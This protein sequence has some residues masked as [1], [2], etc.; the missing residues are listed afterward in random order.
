MSGPKGNLILFLYESALINAGVTSPVSDLSEADMTG[1]NLSD[2]TLNKVKLRNGYVT[3]A[4]PIKWIV[5]SCYKR[6]EHHEHLFQNCSQV[7]ADRHT[8]VYHSSSD[9][10]WDWRQR[11]P[12]RNEQHDASNWHEQYDASNHWHH[13]RVSNWE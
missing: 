3:L 7:C 9:C 4:I 6:K 5:L 12:N 13:H 8:W 2:I 10:L 11:E 1:A